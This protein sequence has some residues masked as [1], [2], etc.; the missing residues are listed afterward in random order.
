MISLNYKTYRINLKYPFGISRSSNTWYDRL[1]LSLSSRGHVGY[2]EAAPNP[3]YGENIDQ[4][5]RVLNSGI[6]LPKNIDTQKRIWNYIKPQLNGIK[7]LEACFNMAIWDI[8]SKMNNI[9]LSELLD[10]DS[11][12]KLQ[13]SYTISLGTQSEILK[14]IEDSKEYNILKVKLGS[15]KRDKAIFR[16]IRSHTDKLIRVD[17]NEGWDI[18][19]AFE[20]SKWLADKNVEFI[21]Q[22][23]PANEIKNTYELKKTS[24]LPIIADENSISSNDIP[25]IHEAFDGINIKLMKCGSIEEA[26]SMIKIAREYD[27][28]IMLGCMVETS[29]G[30]SAVSNLIGEVDYADL[31]GNL[32]IN[33]DPFKGVQVVDG[34]LELSKSHGVGAILNQ[35]KENILI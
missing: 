4:I 26:L 11:T 21:E 9:C 34:F 15:D 24:N 8:W 7:S 33:N 1:L 25:L 29:L 5:N 12:K 20:M 13:T 32:L 35:N 14:K 30:I 17:A 19:T 6:L 31:D 18:D 10:L 28:K 16:K 27:L 23:F 22:P 2:G 3:R